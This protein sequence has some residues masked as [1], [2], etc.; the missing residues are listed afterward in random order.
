MGRSPAQVSTTGAPDSPGVMRSPRCMTSDRPPAVTLVSKPVFST[1][2]PNSTRPSRRGT[3]YCPSPL[4][5]RVTAGNPLPS[6]Q[7]IWPRTGSTGSGRP[8]IQLCRPDH[9]PAAMTTW[10]APMRSPGRTSPATRFLRTIR[11]TAGSPI[12][13]SPPR[14][15][16]EA[17]SAWTSRLFST[18]CIPLK[19]SPPLVSG[20]S[21]GSSARTSSPVSRSTGNPRSLWWRYRMARSSDSSSSKAT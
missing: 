21:M 17:T 9:A 13:N 14:L 7:T 1:V 12:R 15:L 3:R 4:M 18:W 20:E 6:T 10:S 16:T 19:S 2:A 8:G 5:T 11:S